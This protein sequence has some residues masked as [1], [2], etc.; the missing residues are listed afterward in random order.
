MKT[1]FMA[2]T[3]PSGVGKTTIIRE[4]L[5]QDQRFVQI[6]TYATRPLRPGETDRFSLPLPELEAMHKRGEV[7]QPRPIYG[8]SY[9]AALPWTPIRAAFAEGKFP[10]CN[11]TV[12]SIKDLGQ[13]LGSAPFCV[14]IMPPDFDTIIMRLERDGRKPD[15]FRME[16][17]KQEIGELETRY[18]EQ[19]SFKIVNEEGKISEV[20]EE[21]CKAYLR[22]IEL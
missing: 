5:R 7:L 14:Y 22:T 20:A 12:L 3:G 8:G 21:I 2:V 6:K 17:D 13:E 15:P 19:V 11:Y 10:V 16:E 1:K 4:L 18:K 9:F